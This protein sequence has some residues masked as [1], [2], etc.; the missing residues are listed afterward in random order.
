MRWQ[1]KHTPKSNG[2]NCC[3]KA[4]TEHMPTDF[5]TTT[6][7]ALDELDHT[8]AQRPTDDSGQQRAQ[9]LLWKVLHRAINALDTYPG[10]IDNI[11][12]SFWSWA[13]GSTQFNSVLY[14]NERRH[15]QQDPCLNEHTLLAMDA[16]DGKQALDALVKLMGE[17]LPPEL[18]GYSDLFIAANGHI[19][20]AQEARDKIA[21]HTPWVDAWVRRYTLTQTIH[22]NGSAKSEQARHQPKI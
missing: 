11:R 14:I 6:L 20:N 9:I 8:L 21:Q 15:T 2:R 7:L 4:Y 19:N 3:Q 16:V 22:Q 12:L 10:L 5:N 13:D 1:T 18:F 17:L